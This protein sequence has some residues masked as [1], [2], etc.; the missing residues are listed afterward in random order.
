MDQKNQTLTVERLIKS[1]T[2]V[3]EHGEVFT[4]AWMVDFMLQQEGIPEKLKDPFSTFL[5]PAAGDGNFL[6][7]ILSK[8]LEYINA[9]YRGVTRDTKSLW[10]LSSIYGIELLTDN[11]L[12]A[13]ENMLKAYVDSYVSFHDKPLCKQNSV[14]KSARLIIEKNIQQ[15]NA[16]THESESGQPIVF[17]HWWRVT[18]TL[19]N[20]QR[21]LFTYSSL[22][23]KKIVNYES[24]ALFDDVYEPRTLF[25]DDTCCNHGP[26]NTTYRIVPIKEVYKELKK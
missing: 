1:K 20:V 18:G 24:V 2:R 3:Q 16:L 10:A 19:N 22:F 11:L 13:R 15:G 23:H 5:E 8:K 6:V 21:E 14:Y 26:I 9:E 4:P 7:A 12:D 17:S 25:K